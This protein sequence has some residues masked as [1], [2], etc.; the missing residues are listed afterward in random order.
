MNIN[1]DFKPSSYFI[2]RAL[3]EY[4]LTMVKG[5]VL[6]QKLITLNDNGKHA[7]FEELLKLITHSP[8][9]QLGLEAIHP[10]FMGGNYL[11]NLEPG[12]VE[13]A[14]ISINSTT[15]DV[16]CVYAKMH[17]GKICLRVVDEYGG[18]T[19]NEPSELTVKEPLTLGD[20]TNFF[21]NACELEGTLEA[22]F[23]NDLESS[24]DFFTASSDFYPNLDN[25]VREIVEQYFLTNESVDTE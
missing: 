8:E 21:L 10:Q 15:Q 13:I 9:I 22:N 2:P 11:A 3:E 4:L 17:S 16:N 12:E 5:D 24:L 14:R 23:G 1:L 18:E 7:E 20:V 25:L 19:L 6:R